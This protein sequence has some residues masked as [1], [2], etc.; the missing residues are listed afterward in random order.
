VSYDYVA[1]RAVSLR[2]GIPLP[3]GDRRLFRVSVEKNMMFEEIF[4][5]KSRKTEGF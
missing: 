4:D 3:Y 5:L 2:N 1:L